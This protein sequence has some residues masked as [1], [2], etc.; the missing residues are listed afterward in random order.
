MG[1]DN[2]CKLLCE[3]YPEKIAS[4]LMK[5]I[6]GPVTVLDKELSNEP[7]R[8][9]SVIFLKTQDQIIHIEFQVDVQKSK[10][11]ISLRVLDYWVRFYR[12]SGCVFI[13]SMVFRWCR[14]SSF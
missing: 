12:Q 2:I 1:Y 4:W 7:I 6:V 8:A 14:S 10:P 13:A 9:D 5:D 11:H 3:R